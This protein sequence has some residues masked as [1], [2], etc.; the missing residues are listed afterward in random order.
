MLREIDKR[1][2]KSTLAV[3]T[4]RVP[5]VTLATGLDVLGDQGKQIPDA[6]PALIA[7]RPP[8]WAGAPRNHHEALQ[9]N[10]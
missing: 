8:G 2:A 5:Q 1:T 6:D 9:C 4:T 3:T 7:P 10:P